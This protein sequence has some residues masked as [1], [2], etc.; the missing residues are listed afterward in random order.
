MLKPAALVA[1]LALWSVSF[2]QGCDDARKAVT[3]WTYYPIRDMRQSV[4]VDPQRD[5]WSERGPVRYSQAPDSLSAPTIGREAYAAE[6]FPYEVSAA[7]LRAPQ[8]TEASI[9]HGDSLF[10]TI[11]WTC[12]GKTMAGDG[13]VAAKFMV[14]PDL[15]AQMTRDRTDGYLYR[16]IRHGGYLMPAYGNMM[17]AHDSW[18]VVHYLRQM[19]RTSPR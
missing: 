18:S 2:Q 6:I 4:A 15:L 5:A 13:P 7:R 19:Q 17:S 8:A 10:R 3:R 11:C 16:Y 12:H 1:F 14:P 9:A